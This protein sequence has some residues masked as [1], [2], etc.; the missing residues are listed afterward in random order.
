MESRIESKK[1]RVSNVEFKV[2]FVL[3]KDDYYSDFNQFIKKIKE[4]L[5][6]RDGFRG[7]DTPDK[8]VRSQ[9]GLEALQEVCSNLLEKEID[10][11]KKEEAGDENVVIDH[12]LCKS[13]FPTSSS[14]FLK[15]YGDITFEYLFGF[16]GNFDVKDWIENKCKEVSAERLY[17]EDIDE[18]KLKKM[19]KEVM[20]LTELGEDKK[21]VDF[22]DAV[23]LKDENSENTFVVHEG[24]FKVNGSV[25]ELKGK[26]IGDKVEFCLEDDKNVDLGGEF[27]NL[28][29][30]KFNKGEN[31][32]EIYCVRSFEKKKVDKEFLNRFLFGGEGDFT[33]KKWLCDKL[34]IDSVSILDEDYVL[35]DNVEEVE[36][37]FEGK[38]KNIFLVHCNYYLKKMFR[39]E[40]KERLIKSVNIEAPVELLKKKIDFFVNNNRTK[41]KL[42]DYFYDK[43]VEFFINQMK[44]NKIFKELAKVFNVKVEN[45]DIEAFVAVKK[46]IE[47][48]D[49]KDVI[50]GKLEQKYIDGIIEG[51][52]ET[53][54]VL[55][56]KVIESV[57]VDK[58]KVVDKKIDYREYLK[59]FGV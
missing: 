7:K 56:M 23:F 12:I 53:E 34:N 1:E 58:L 10:K 46:Y 26:K 47:N 50:N 55:Q 51:E 5:K 24:E 18:D 52:N 29:D 16:I 54:N 32:F 33:S 27:N 44:L 17:C 39:M 30:V 4:G 9:Y 35:P 42:P 6:R 28:V 59:M 25:F 41:D 14:F 31:V 49:E 22:G 19:V 43:Y 57:L 15:G 37:I 40:V 48:G 2:S 20:F 11:V 13:T 36:K 21:S 38:M 8:V 3:H 45:E